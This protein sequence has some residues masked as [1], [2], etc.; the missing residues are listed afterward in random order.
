[1]HRER[2]ACSSL[3]DNAPFRR[4]NT[5]CQMPSPEENFNAFNA[6]MSSHTVNNRHL[7]IYCSYISPAQPQTLSLLLPWITTCKSSRVWLL[8]T[9]AGIGKRK[10]SRCQWH[11]TQPVASVKHQI[12]ACLLFYPSIILKEEVN[13]KDKLFLQRNEYGRSELCLLA[14][15]Y[16]SA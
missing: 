5:S 11:L 6:I 15:Q 1:M 7:M 10:I 4:R 14:D 3:A 13:H 12:A 16:F 9:L 8:F 2:S